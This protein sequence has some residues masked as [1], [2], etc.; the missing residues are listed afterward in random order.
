VLTNYIHVVNTVGINEVS[1][2]FHLTVTPNPFSNQSFISYIL[3]EDQHISISLTDI[4]GKQIIL[5]DEK[6]SAG[7]HQMKMDAD[8]QRLSKGLYLLELRGLNAKTTIK[9]IIY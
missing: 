7:S 5:K 6:Q 2:H 9:L 3:N 8:K 1:D 4:L